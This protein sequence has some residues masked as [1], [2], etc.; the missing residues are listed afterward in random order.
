MPSLSVQQFGMDRINEQKR[1]N[2][3]QKRLHSDFWLKVEREKEEIEARL[4][5]RKRIKKGL[6]TSHITNWTLF[7]PGT[8]STRISQ[9]KF[10]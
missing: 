10:L 3:E 7:L 9:K 6:A 8:Q 4:Y 5:V 2:E 1:S